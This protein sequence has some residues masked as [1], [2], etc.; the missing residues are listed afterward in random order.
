M[1]AAG[2]APD[3]TRPAFPRA[4]WVA[5]AW[6]GFWVPAYAVNYGLGNFLALCDVAVVVTVAGL[7]AGS[8]LLLSTQALSALLVQVAWVVDVAHRLL[9]GRHLVGGTEYMWDGSIPL[10]LRL[11]SLFHAALPVV[12]VW[13]L[14]RV[15]YDRRALPVQTALAAALFALSRLTDPAKN[16]NYAFREPFR[17]LALEPWPLH[18]AFLTGSLFLLAYWPTHL[19]LARL[20]RA[21]SRP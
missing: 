16:L 3:P 14:R 17:G 7:W 18:V 1:A 15:G 11:L 5:V 2:A 8:P 20:F 12:L 21:R 9:L 13:A 4:R 6:L 19:A 10:W